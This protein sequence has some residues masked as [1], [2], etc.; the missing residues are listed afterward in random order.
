MA[1][2][3]YLDAS[4]VLRL[5]FGEPAAFEGLLVDPV[6]S[7]LCEVECLRTIDRKLCGRVLSADQALAARSRV[8]ALLSATARV[9]VTATVLLRAGQPLPA[10][11]G[12]LDA[13]H[14]GTAL[15]LREQ[16][17][18]DVEMVTHDLQLALCARLCGVTVLG[19]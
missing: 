19:V 1:A 18:T 10:P 6:T 17:G 2:R 16:T 3:S 4:V 8:L 13:I 14:L 5:A 12:T 11:L 15:L 7:A 9:D